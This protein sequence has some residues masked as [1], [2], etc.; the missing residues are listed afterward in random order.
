M[1]LPQGELLRRRVL[2]DVGT[3]LATALDRELTGYARLEPQETLLLGADGVGVLT[4]EAG[5]PVAAY[6]TGTD[7]GGP[8]AVA[9]IGQRGPYRLELYELDAGVI[10]R[11]HEDD[12]LLVPPAMPASQ[13]GGDPELQ[14]R[15]RK[16]A[17]AERLGD[18]QPTENRLAAVEEF[19]DDSDRVEKIQERARTEAESRADDWNFPTDQT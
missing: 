14:E 2:T 18:E 5:V 13:L 12:S 8:D 16:Q 7:A 6:H 11:I 19:L 9:D 3:V 1:N 10:E 15:T 17:P 4:F